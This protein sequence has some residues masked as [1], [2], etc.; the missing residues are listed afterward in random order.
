VTRKIKAYLAA[1]ALVLS[2]CSPAFALY[3]S[4][5]NINYEVDPGWTAV[6][7]LDNEF[8]SVYTR[9]NDLYSMQGSASEPTTKWTN[10]IWF[11][12]ALHIFEYYN[13]STWVQLGASGNYISGVSMDSGATGTVRSAYLEAESTTNLIVPATAASP[14]T[15]DVDSVLLQ[16]TTDTNLDFTGASADTY[17]VYAT[18]DGTSTNFQLARAVLSGYTQGAGERIIGEVVYS[19]SA[20]SFIKP[21]VA[22][23]PARAAAPDG[24]F[25]VYRTNAAENVADNVAETIKFNIETIDEDSYY[26]PA[27]GKY[28]PTRV[29]YYELHASAQFAIDNDPDAVDMIASVEIQQ[30]GTAVCGGY[31]FFTSDTGDATRTSTTNTLGLKGNLMRVQPQASC[32]LY[33]DGDDYFTVEVLQNS[34][35]SDTYTLRSPT[36]HSTAF[37]GR[38]I[39]RR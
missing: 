17:A 6:Q 10:M 15:I 16:N 18:R 37:W 26:D 21:Y 12:T 28:S 5:V 29:G 3:S 9:I 11:N 31:A 30:N 25:D 32:V 19:G 1:V 8:S 4:G 34:F 39:G 27:T 13:G 23:L 33:N 20:F 22:Q 35:P 2:S 36:A 7:Q 14:A 24:L 38:W